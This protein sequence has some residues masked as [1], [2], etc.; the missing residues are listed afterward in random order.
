MNDNYERCL[1]NI[2]NYYDMSVISFDDGYFILEDESGY[3]YKYHFSHILNKYDIN[4][5]G[6]NEFCNFNFSKFL[7]NDYNHLKHV[8]GDCLT[9]KSK[10]EI[11]CSRCQNTFISS[12]SSIKNSNDTCRKHFPR[13]EKIIKEKIVKLKKEKINKK[14]T[15]ENNFS[16]DHPELEKEWDYG[17]NG[18]IIIGY[19]KHSKKKHWWK[20]S[21][22]GYEWETSLRNRIVFNTGCRMCSY[23]KKDSEI[24]KEVYS[25]LQTLS[26]KILRE[27]QCTLIVLNPKT[28]RRMFYDN[29]LYEIKLIIEVH[30]HQ[31]YDPNNGIHRFEAKR[32]S[33][34]CNDAFLEMKFRDEYKKSF[35]LDNGYNY[36]EIPYSDVENG[37]YKEKI[38]NKISEILKSSF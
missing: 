2:K 5:F 8:S 28:N 18:D 14:I 31:H 30:G 21:S 9:I 25:F 34:T 15:F 35:C 38:I 33:I 16:E 20:C 32:K 1:N 36:L 37:T 10:I 19:G 3:L 23:K 17:K 24:Q 6:N 27:D 22:C 26:Y 29:E 12:Y 4:I 11:Y 7:E 13:K